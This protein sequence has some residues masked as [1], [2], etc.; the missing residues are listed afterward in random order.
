[1]PQQPRVLEPSYGDDYS[2]SA[3]V[4]DRS[5]NTG[6]TDDSSN[7]GGRPPPG[8]EASTRNN[9]T[10]PLLTDQGDSPGREAQGGSLHREVNAS[11]NAPIN[12]DRDRDVHGSR[13]Y[14]EGSRSGTKSRIHWS[15][16][17]TMVICFLFSLVLGLGH[18]FYHS[19]LA[20]RP[21]GDAS[22]QQWIRGLVDNAIL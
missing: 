22:R 1:M 20:G 13:T 9:E 18:H 16:P 21:A 7:R 10:A 2:I 4:E 5:L 6:S 3:L 8:E 11:D 19:S 15:S 14:P 17:T 12:E